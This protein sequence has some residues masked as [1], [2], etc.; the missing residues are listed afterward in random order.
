MS[1][2]K[3]TR[4]RNGKLIEYWQESYRVP[5][6]KTPVTKCLGPVNPK[7]KKIDLGGTIKGAVAFGVTAAL[8]KLGPPGGK[9][10]KSKAYE[11]TRPGHTFRAV[12][13]QL[14]EK[15]GIDRSSPEAW[16][17]SH[18][19]LPAEM[20]QEMMKATTAAA[21]T[22]HAAMA[23]AKAQTPSDRTS[24]PSEAPIPDE[25]TDTGDSS[26]GEGKDGG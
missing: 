14:D 23:E 22:Y 10:F 17:A 21:R 11:P 4:Y 2:Y 8:G 16:R 24:D 13:R 7:R 15:Y 19:R 9:A 5:G 6:R 3:V 1:I 12:E 18:A 20:A 26:A 25:D